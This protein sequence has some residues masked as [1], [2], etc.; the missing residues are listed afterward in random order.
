MDMN[1]ILPALSAVL[2]QPTP[3]ALWQLRGYLLAEDVPASAPAVHTC[4]SFYHFLNQ[5]SASATSR[6]YSHFASLLDMGAVGGVAVQNLL[7]GDRT[8]EW[9]QRL[10]IGGVGEGL[11]VLAARQYVKAWE[12]ELRA[13]YQAAAWTLHEALWAFSTQMKPE[14]D[15]AERLRLIGDLIKPLRQPDVSGAAKAAL[16]VRL[17]QLLLLVQLSP[18][19]GAT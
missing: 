14:I 18:Y 16:I 4:T 3:A 11:M 8:P 2:A 6:Q 15:A 17:F 12:E 10:L 9:W 5:L 13:E 1:P 7:E 19:L